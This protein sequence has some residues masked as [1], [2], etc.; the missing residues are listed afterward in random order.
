MTG[1]PDLTILGAGMLRRDPLV[2]QSY[3]GT[4]TIVGFP[5]Q[6]TATV[7]ADADGRFFALS[8]RAAPKPPAV[9]DHLRLPGLIEGE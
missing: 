3:L 7:E 8:F 2:E 4:A 5:Y 6:L 1:A 9:P